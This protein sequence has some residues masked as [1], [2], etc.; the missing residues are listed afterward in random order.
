MP[1][2]NY[3]D[4]LRKR[5]NPAF[6]NPCHSPDSGEF[7]ETEGVPA[8]VL[9]ETIG[10]SPEDKK[11]YIQEYLDNERH[12]KLS[13]HYGQEMPP[14]LGGVQW[15]W[16]GYSQIITSAAQDVIEGIPRDEYSDYGRDA[17]SAAETILQTLSLPSSKTD[18]KTYSGHHRSQEDI[19]N[20]IKDGFLSFPLVAT[21]PDR[22]LAEAYAGTGTS[23]I[24]EF[25]PGSQGKF[26][27]ENEFIQTGEYQITSHS[28]KG[29]QTTIKLEQTKRTEV[30]V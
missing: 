4:I 23:V 1:T 12:D 24:Y 10:L 29:N 13:T 25:P 27:R 8:D 17:E 6:S 21:S 14:S 3:L 16:E 18:V 11:A 30:P 20:Q 7:C 15:A 22:N 5:A 2:I 26:Y 28:R 9:K 19:N